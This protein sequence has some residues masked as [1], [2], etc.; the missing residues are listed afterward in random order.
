[1]AVVTWGRPTLR[2]SYWAVFAVAP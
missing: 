2:Q 1:V